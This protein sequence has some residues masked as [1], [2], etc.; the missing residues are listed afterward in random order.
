MCI[1]D[2]IFCK[3]TDY[4]SVILLT[5]N[6]LTKLFRYRLC[7]GVAGECRTVIE[8]LSPPSRNL[9]LHLARVFSCWRKEMCFFDLPNAFAGRNIIKKNLGL[10]LKIMVVKPLGKVPAAVPQPAYSLP[11][12][13]KIGPGGH[14]VCKRGK[15][16]RRNGCFRCRDCTKS[17]LESILSANVARVFAKTDAFA[18]AIA[19]NR[20]WR[21]FCLQTW[22]GFSPKRMLSLP[23]LHEID[24]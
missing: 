11:R 15:G 6:T 17:A 7:A 19:Q 21:A 22:Q 9:K 4:L 3:S 2:N 12:L 5:F 10:N 13:H 18:A 20:P 23:R 8:S 16:F 24:H 1:H 14:S